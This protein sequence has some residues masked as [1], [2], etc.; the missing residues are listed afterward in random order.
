[1]NEPRIHPDPWPAELRLQADWGYLRDHISLGDAA[2][3]TNHSK[4]DL[5]LRLWQ[6][7]GKPK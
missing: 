4:A 7:L 1:M 5:D 2:D 6:M 3:L